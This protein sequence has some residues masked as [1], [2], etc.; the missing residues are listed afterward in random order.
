MNR[1]YWVKTQLSRLKTQLSR[2]VVERLKTRQKRYLKRLKTNVTFHSLVFLLSFKLQFFRRSEPS[3]RTIF[4]MSRNTKFTNV[5]RGSVCESRKN[6]S[7]YPFVPLVKSTLK[8][9]DSSKRLDA[10]V[11]ICTTCSLRG[12]KSDSKRT[13]SR[14]MSLESW[15]L[16]RFWLTIHICVHSIVFAR[17]GSGFWFRILVTNGVMFGYM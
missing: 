6:D 11:C 17:F 16:F 3:F 4:Y 1:R 9:L 2:I 13:K 14:V 10:A 5:V 15:V 7:P 12:L 8:T